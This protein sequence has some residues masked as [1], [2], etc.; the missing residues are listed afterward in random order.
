M[1]SVQV[2]VLFDFGTLAEDLGDNLMYHTWCYFCIERS[3]SFQ[4]L[5]A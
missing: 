3:C 4:M 1:G 5:P 2:G